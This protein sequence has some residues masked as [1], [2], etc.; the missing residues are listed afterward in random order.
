MLIIVA[1]F[2]FLMLVYKNKTNY[3][4]FLEKQ[5]SDDK[6]S[7]DEEKSKLALETKKE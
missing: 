5:I 1:I 6:K 4:K 3:V 7:A 2:I